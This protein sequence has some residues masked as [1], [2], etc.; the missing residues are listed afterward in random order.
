MTKELFTKL[1]SFLLQDDILWESSTVTEYLIDA[2]RFR[3]D[4]SL[5]EIEDRVDK[6][7]IRL[8]L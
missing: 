4:L 2:G 7:I 6:L 8:G 3:T 5:S 1:G